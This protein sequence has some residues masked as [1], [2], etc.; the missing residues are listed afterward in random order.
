M[1]QERNLIVEGDSIH[2]K[3]V[4]TLSEQWCERLY[5]FSFNCE[6]LICLLI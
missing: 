1:N 6:N 4:H 2:L 3:M 5:P